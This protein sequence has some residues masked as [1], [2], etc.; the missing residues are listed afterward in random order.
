MQR[1]VLRKRKARPEETRSDL[2]AQA[3]ASTAHLRSLAALT[4]SLPTRL[5]ASHA[6]A[7][8]RDAAAGDAATVTAQGVVRELGRIVTDTAKALEG[9]V[10]CWSRSSEQLL[11]YAVALESVGGEESLVLAAGLLGRKKD[12]VGSAS[13]LAR[14][15]VGEGIEQVLE[16]SVRVRAGPCEASVSGPGLLGFVA[17]A[18]EGIN[19]AVRVCLRDER[20]EEVASAGPSDVCVSVEGGE[21]VSAEAL[22]VGEVETCYTVPEGRGSVCVHVSV[23]GKT[24][25]SSPFPVGVSSDCIVCVCCCVLLYMFVCCCV[26]L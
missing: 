22:A 6:D 11:A 17:G 23:L 20:D 25:P 5:H 26:L 2:C 9:E 15:C 14:V 7:V 3:D 1:R 8:T 4:A 13:W 18:G 24:L 21:V 12:W 10:E 16:D 19:N